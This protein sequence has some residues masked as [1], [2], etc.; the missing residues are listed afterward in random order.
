MNDYAVCLVHFSQSSVRGL[1]CLVLTPFGSPSSFAPSP[2]PPKFGMSHI[3]KIVPGP[4]I[5]RDKAA[6]SAGLTLPINNGLVE[7]KVNKLKLIKRMG[8]G[9]AGFPLLR[10]RIP[11]AL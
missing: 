6:V 7:G 8:Y 2:V 1:F 11:H 3:T 4:G 9:R 10:Q 5:E